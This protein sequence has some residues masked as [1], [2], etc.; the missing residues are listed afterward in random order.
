M[1]ESIHTV[2]QDVS[3]LSKA[4]V[5]AACGECRD[6]LSHVLRGLFAGFGSMGKVLEMHSRMLNSHSEAFGIIAQSGMESI[7]HDPLEAIRRQ[8][9]ADNTIRNMQIERKCD[10]WLVTLFYPNVQIGHGQTWE[11][12]YANA[13][14]DQIEYEMERLARRAAEKEVTND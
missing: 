5:E 4:D 12:A 8:C 13:R 9:A 7:P 11:T 3:S 10:E 1:R 2:Y 6:K 14:A